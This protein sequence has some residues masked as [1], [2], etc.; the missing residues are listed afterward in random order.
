MSF[1]FTVGIFVFILL[2]SKDAS[3]LMFS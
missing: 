3:N 2:I 1:R